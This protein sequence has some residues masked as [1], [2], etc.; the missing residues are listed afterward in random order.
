TIEEYRQ[1]DC[2]SDCVG[3]VNGGGWPYAWTVHAPLYVTEEANCTSYCNGSLRIW[4]NEVLECV[5]GRLK[6][7]HT[8]VLFSY[9]A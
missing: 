2:N 1:A 8:I 9:G 5:F 3:A 7:A 6:P 4:G